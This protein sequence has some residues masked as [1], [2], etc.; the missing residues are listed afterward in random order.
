[1]APT[2]CP[3]CTVRLKTKG[4]RL[5]CPE[6]GYYYI[7]NRGSYATAS[8]EA[9]TASKDTYATSPKAYSVK[10][11]A[12]PPVTPTITV[13][14]TK[15]TKSNP[16]AAI[17]IAV[18]TFIGI[19]AIAVGIILSTVFSE[20]SSSVT[21]SEDVARSQIIKSQD[22]KEIFVRSLP[23][24]AYF[25]NVVS[26][27]FGKDYTEVTPDE[28]SSVAELQF[29]YDDDYN[30]CIY[31]I[32]SDGTY[33]NFY[34]DENLSMD[35]KDLSCFPQVTA[36]NLEA[37][38]YLSDGSLYGMEQL[39]SISSHM[40]LQKLANEVLYPEQLTDIG[41]YSAYDLQNLNDLTL[42]PNVIS[43]SV[44][45]WNLE[46]I[47]GLS[48]ATQIEHLSLI[49]CDRLDDFAPLYDMT[50][51]KSLYIDS[52]SLKKSAL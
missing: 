17:L 42:F 43:L 15:T 9:Y 12:K 48:E 44:D 10:K 39:T 23:E 20:V 19:M 4:D 24:S 28:L 50:N 33:R 22:D 27:I 3:I 34:A 13:Q 21:D 38:S 1:M 29:Y 51:L 32:M 35:T 37:I 6:C 36:L 31:A 47:D 45:E 46:N 7:P 18:I 41:I 5:V 30:T 52:D 2:K 25:Q 8:T 16:A 49:G 14:T 11:V 40:G 26:Q